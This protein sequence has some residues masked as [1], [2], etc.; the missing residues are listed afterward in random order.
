MKSPVGNEKKA[1]VGKAQAMNPSAGGL[2]EA[3]KYLE[4]D[5]PNYNRKDLP[6]PKGGKGPA[7]GSKG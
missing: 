1:A 2:G 3:K 5:V 4:Q 6:K 7:S